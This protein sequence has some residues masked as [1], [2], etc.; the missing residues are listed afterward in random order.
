[1][2]TTACAVALST[3]QSI[4][5]VK[6]V[7]HLYLATFHRLVAII[8]WS[9]IT[10]IFEYHDMFSFPLT[11]FS[12][13]NKRQNFLLMKVPCSSFFLHIWKFLD[14]IG[15]S[16]IYFCCKVLKSLCLSFSFGSFMMGISSGRRLLTDKTADVS[17]SVCDF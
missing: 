6:E 5:V 4:L 17:V 10:F 8:R 1:M 16:C 15:H 7:L 9:E 11:F 3:I 13:L 2:L 14:V 12:Y